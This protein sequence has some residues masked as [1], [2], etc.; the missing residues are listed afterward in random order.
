MHGSRAGPIHEKIPALRSLLA[1]RHGSMSSTS[2]PQSQLHMD[3]AM[4]VRTSFRQ[5]E[6]VPSTMSTDLSNDSELRSAQSS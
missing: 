5:V 4:H 6:G 1:V 3:K 2:T